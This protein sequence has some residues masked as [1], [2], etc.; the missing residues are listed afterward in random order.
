VVSENASVSRNAAA[1]A[2][3]DGYRARYLEELKDVA[4]DD[5]YFGRKE[6]LLAR[7]GE[8]QI[9][10]LVARRMHYHKT[11]GTTENAGAGTP[12]VYLNSPPD[13]CQDR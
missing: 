10:T 1:T 3:L 8:L 11:V 9:R 2:F 4:P 13:L 5:V 7:R 12:E 6:A